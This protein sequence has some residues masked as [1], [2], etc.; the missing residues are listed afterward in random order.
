V[1]PFGHGL[2]VAA[3]PR[4]SDDDGNSKHRFS[5]FAV[6]ENDGEKGCS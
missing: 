2:A 4:A 6:S 3:G 1:D 5:F